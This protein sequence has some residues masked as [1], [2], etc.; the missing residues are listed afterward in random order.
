[1]ITDKQE[2]QGKIKNRWRLGFYLFIHAYRS[3][4]QVI[5]FT[6]SAYYFTSTTDLFTV[7]NVNSNFF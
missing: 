1:M 4:V 7:Q 2:Y 6:V 5:M 3:K